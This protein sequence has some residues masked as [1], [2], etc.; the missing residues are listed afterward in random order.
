MRLAG[1]VAIITG[2]AGGIGRA[3]TRVF[4]R[5]GAQV[6]FVDINDEQGLAL[7]EEL[8]GAG[9][10]LN[11]DISATGSAEQIRD[12]AVEAFGGINILVNNA[13]A[14]RQAPLLDTTPEMFDLSFNTGFYPVVHLMQACHD[15][16]AKTKGSVINFASSAGLDGMPTQ[17]SYAAAKEAVRGLSRVA[18]NEWAPEGIR[19]NVICPFAAT[20]GVLAWQE[21][22][23]E[24]AAATAAKVPL[25]RIGDPETDI[26]PVAVFLAS[27]DS[28]YMTG[29]TLMA[30]GGTIK[31]R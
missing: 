28:K 9:K 5:E 1:K 13:H 24:R 26:A 17:A 31:L 30:E 29:Q 2:G 12:A 22:F 8:A 4:A 19:V 6:L 14:S 18:A 20:E 11:V 25:G 16:L 3:L 27:E 21:A 23:P 15:E 10:F 7:E